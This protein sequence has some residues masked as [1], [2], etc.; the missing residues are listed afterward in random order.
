MIDVYFKKGTEM[1]AVRIQGTRLSFAQLRGQVVKYAPIEGLKLSISGIVKEFPDLDG[2]PVAEM[3]KIAIERF[4]K[5]IEKM[6]T[7]SERAEYVTE[8]L[9]KHFYT[10]I[11]HKKAGF[12]PRILGKK[13]GKNG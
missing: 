4:K 1:I 12:R 7:E 2:K 8:D 11:L 3:R 10:P 13:G 9:K 6:G 5:H